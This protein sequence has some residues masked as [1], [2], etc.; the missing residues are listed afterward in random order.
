MLMVKID[1]KIDVVA[2]FNFLKIIME[3]ST[4]L[5]GLKIKL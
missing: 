2:I 3:H 4:I 1:D 5:G